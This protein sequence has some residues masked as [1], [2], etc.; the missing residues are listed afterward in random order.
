M[1]SKA[2]LFLPCCTLLAAVACYSPNMDSTS[3]PS[4]DESS[5]GT[6]PTSSATLGTMS[7]SAS[8]SATDP[9]G[10]SSDS[11]MVSTD[12]DPSDPDSESSAEATSGS[13]GGPVEPFCGDLHVD[14]GED[15]DNGDDNALDAECRPDCTLAS[16]GDGDI[17]AGVEGCDDGVDNNVLELGA[18]APDCSRVIEERRIELGEFVLVGNFGANPVAFADSLCQPGYSAMFAFPGVRE[19]ALNP[20]DPTGSIDWVLQPYTAYVGEQEEVV[21]ITDDVPLLGVRDGAQQGLLA[22]IT[23]LCPEGNFCLHGRP[24]TGLD[25]DWTTSTTE[26]CDG[27]TSSTDT[28]SARRGAAGSTVTYLYDSALTTGCDFGPLSSTDIYCVEQ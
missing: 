2:S 28:D 20:Y 15:C 23:A 16:C 3:G 6:S 27:W 25:T 4:E 18:C 7:S 26:D 13:S 17:W 5:G 9:T 19:A 24:L 10:P 21:W 1:Q 12:V 22:G 8:M 11:S 14:P